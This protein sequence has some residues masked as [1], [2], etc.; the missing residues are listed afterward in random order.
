MSDYSTERDFYAREKEYYAKN[1]FF[2]IKCGKEVTSEEVYCAHC[3][4][5]V[6]QTQGDI[7]PD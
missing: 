4:K 5:I 7:C 1:R 3:F 6:E 2:C